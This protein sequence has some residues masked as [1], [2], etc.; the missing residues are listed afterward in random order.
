M[1]SGI[2]ALTHPSRPL[3]SHTSLERAHHVR[4]EFLFKF[5]A[6]LNDLIAWSRKPNGVVL[7]ILDIQSETGII[8]KRNTAVLCV[9]QNTLKKAKPLAITYMTM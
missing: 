5:P 7:S 9:F 4:G 6:E 3:A 2:E 1:S 8:T